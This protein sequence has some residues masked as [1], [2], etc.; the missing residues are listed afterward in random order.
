MQPRP[1]KS[2]LRKQIRKENK[3]HEVKTP[4]AGNAEGLNMENQTKPQEDTTAQAFAKDLVQILPSFSE[5]SNL[6]RDGICQGV[7]LMFE[8]LCNALP[9]DVRVIPLPLGLVMHFWISRTAQ[10]M[11]C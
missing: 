3:M 11:G 9:Q 2:V 4:S 10:L 6:W 7:T 1:A 5:V 8:A